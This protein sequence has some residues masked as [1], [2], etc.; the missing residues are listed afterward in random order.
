MSGTYGFFSVVLCSSLC[1]DLALSCML[2]AFSVSKKL[3]AALYALP[4][5]DIKN[6]YEIS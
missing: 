1:P 2:G 6:I 5:S 4:G 3:L